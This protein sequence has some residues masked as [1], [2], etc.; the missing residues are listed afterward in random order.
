MKVNKKINSDENCFSVRSLITRN[1]SSLKSSFGDK[2]VSIGWDVQW[3]NNKLI[4]EYTV[5]LEFKK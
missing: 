2:F 1:P 5:S 3:D 4:K